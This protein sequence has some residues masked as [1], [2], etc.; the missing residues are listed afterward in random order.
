MS[1]SNSYSKIARKSFHCSL[2]YGIMWW[3]GFEYKDCPLE[4]SNRDMPECKECKLRIDK[5]WENNKQTWKDKVIKK[6][7]RRQNIKGKK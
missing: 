1:R 4:P 3:R 6:K 2:G 7:K 5:K